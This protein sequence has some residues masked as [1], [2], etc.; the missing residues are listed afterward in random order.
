MKTSTSTRFDLARSIVLLGA[1]LA[2]TG[3]ST[4][5]AAQS[6]GTQPSVA[7]S[8][9]VVSGNP[10]GHSG[11]KQLIKPG[12]RTCLQQT[13]SLIPP[14]KGHCLS[15]PG[16]SYSGE[17]LRNTGAIDNARSLQMLDPS[18]SRGH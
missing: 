16:R 8:A 15:A 1:L 7:P 11:T 18:I 13:G 17:E 3:G 14:K 12:D 2:G 6:T 4:N 5:A 10:D 9:N